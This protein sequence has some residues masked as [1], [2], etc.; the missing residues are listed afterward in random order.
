MPL[1]T[2]EQLD[3]LQEFINIGVGRAAGMLNEMVESPIFLNVPVLKVFTTEALKREVV[4]RFSNHCLSIVRLNFSGVFSGSAELVFPTESASALVSLL[5][6]EDR[7]SPDLD[8][9][10]IGTLTEVGNIVINGV[11]GSI[12]NLLKQQMDYMLPIYFEDTI[13]GL[14]NSSYSFDADTV[15]LLAQTKFEIKQLEIMGEIILIFE[16]SS[17]GE[18]LGRIDEELSLLSQS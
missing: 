4:A 15:F 9:V 2:E 6:G 17:F 12:S 3:A 7:N 11:L 1:I 18:L 16:M 14:L 8:E 5:T 10:K 13:E